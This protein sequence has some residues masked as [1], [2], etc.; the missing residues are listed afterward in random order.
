M[1]RNLLEHLER[2]TPR[3]TSYPTAAQFHSGISADTYECWLATLPADEAISLYVHIPFC[4][5]LCLYCGCHTT[6][7]RGYAPV[8]AYIDLL[9]REIFLVGQIIGR[10]KVSQVHWGGGTPTMLVPRDFLRVNG[11]SRKTVQLQPAD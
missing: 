6:V 7:A 3:Y 11:H 5:E 1:Q 8:A 4:A 9:E 2:R 10:R